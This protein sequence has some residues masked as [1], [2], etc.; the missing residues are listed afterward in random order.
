M[1]L[2][3]GHYIALSPVCY[4]AGLSILLCCVCFTISLSVVLFI[5]C[6][7]CLSNEFLVC[8]MSLSPIY[9]FLPVKCF[10]F[11]CL[12]FCVPVKCLFIASMSFELLSCLLYMSACCTRLPPGRRMKKKFVYVCVCVHACTGMQVIVCVS[13]GEG[14]ANKTHF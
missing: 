7:S 10:F 1:S 11:T 12:L 3:A 14:G 9:C 6:V 4:T 8:L 2:F 13:R 5:C